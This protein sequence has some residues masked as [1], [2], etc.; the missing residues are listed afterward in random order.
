MNGL[1]SKDAVD[2]IFQ[3]IL[4]D[5]KTLKGLKIVT[6]EELCILLSEVMNLIMND[7][8]KSLSLNLSDATARLNFENTF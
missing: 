4:V 8:N 2:L 6:D 3:H 5:W 1:L 7:K